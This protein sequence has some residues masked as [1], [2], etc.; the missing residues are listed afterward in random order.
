VMGAV[1]SAAG[2]RA[3]FGTAAI[4]AMCA[5]ALLQLVVLRRPSE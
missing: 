1:A 5:L 2:Y 4:S 3:A